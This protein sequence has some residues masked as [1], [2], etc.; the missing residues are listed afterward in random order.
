MS[1]YVIL[2]EYNNP[3]KIQL[4]VTLDTFSESVNLMSWYF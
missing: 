2:L 1:D 4:E 3:I